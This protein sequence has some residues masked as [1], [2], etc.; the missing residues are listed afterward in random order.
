[1]QFLQVVVDVLFELQHTFGRKGVG[2]RLP[3]PGV[4]GTIPSVEQASPNG[5]ESVIVLALQEAVA[6]AVDLGNGVCISN[7]DMVRL[8]TDKL[9]K[10]F[11]CF[12]NGKEALPA[13]AL[14]KQP[15][16]GPSGWEWRRYVADLPVTKIWEKIEENRQ[17]KDGIRCQ[18]K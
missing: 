4:L 10:L 3:L 16:I 12:V 15:E 13:A 8:N 17:K 11:V 14:V 7:A 1:M 6:M 18:E 2:D 9:S 5:Y